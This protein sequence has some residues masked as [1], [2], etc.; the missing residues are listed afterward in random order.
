MSLRLEV[1]DLSLAG[2]QRERAG[3]LTGVDVAAQMVAD[4]S[5]ASRRQSDFFGFHEHVDLLT[6]LRSLFRLDIARFVSPDE[7][8]LLS[9]RLPC[10]TIWCTFTSSRPC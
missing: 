4:A 8:G 2:N 7:S 3:Q 5:E 9:C 6:R 10:S 1:G